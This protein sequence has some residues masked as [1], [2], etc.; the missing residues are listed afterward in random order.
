[1]S[2]I[3]QAI[4]PNPHTNLLN[5]Y[6][7]I[8]NK[9]GFQPKKNHL[10]VTSGSCH[11]TRVPRTP[12]T[13]QGSVNTLKCYSSLVKRQCSGYFEEYWV[14]LIHLE[15]NS[16]RILGTVKEIRVSG[17]SRRNNGTQWEN[18]LE[19]QQSHTALS[20]TL[21]PIIAYAKFVHVNKSPSQMIINGMTR[22][23]TQNVILIAKTKRVRVTL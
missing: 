11:G 22:Q 20:A 19:L 13:N 12:F 18:R 15:E 8:A 10:L 2:A 1:M 4:A 23:P 17:H 14:R 9:M 6:I 21:T 5:V 3:P 7:Q 16:F